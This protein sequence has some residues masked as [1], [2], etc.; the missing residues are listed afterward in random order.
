MAFVRHG[1]RIRNF[2]KHHL[3][4]RC[5][6]HSVGPS[7]SLSQIHYLGLNMSDLVEEAIRQVSWTRAEMET[8]LL[9]R[10]SLLEGPEQRR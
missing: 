5:L 1:A 8:E 10:K 3:Q 6:M 7:W 9:G 2:S 4:V